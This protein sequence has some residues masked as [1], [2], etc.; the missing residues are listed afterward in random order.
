MK[1]IKLEVKKNNYENY[2]QYAY[3]KSKNYK[4]KTKKV[5]KKIYKVQK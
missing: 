3:N 1:I 2:F 4:Q 5:N